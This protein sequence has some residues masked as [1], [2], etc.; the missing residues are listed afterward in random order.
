MKT[1]CDV[2]YIPCGPIIVKHFGVDSRIAPSQLETSLQSN[3]VSH[4]LG[5]NLESA[6][7]FN[8]QVLVMSNYKDMY[9]HFS[10]PFITL[11]F[12]PRVWRYHNGCQNSLK[13][14]DKWIH[15]ERLISYV[16]QVVVFYFDITANLLI[17][18]LAQDRYPGKNIVGVKISLY[19]DAWPGYALLKWLNHT[20]IVLQ[21][22]VGEVKGKRKYTWPPWIQ[23]Y[24]W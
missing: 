21:T 2:Y 4:W 14:H 3:A 10:S 11:M 17:G 5:V 6:L 12:L 20:N 1:S 7:H 23:P 8:S 9:K 18:Y 15:T 22:W 19:T 13:C 16:W 24:R